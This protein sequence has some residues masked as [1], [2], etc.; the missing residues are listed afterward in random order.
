MAGPAGHTVSA[1][2]FGRRI[3]FEDLATGGSFMVFDRSRDIL[4]GI[5][6]FTQFSSTKVAGSVRHAGS[7]P[8]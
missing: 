2:Q 1:Q 4:D 3:C 8:R 5:R 7:V 6:N